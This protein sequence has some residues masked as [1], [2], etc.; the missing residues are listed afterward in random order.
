MRDLAIFEQPTG[1][2]MSAETIGVAG[3]GMRSGPA[4]LPQVLQN[5]L[6]TQ[7]CVC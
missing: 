3:I 2:G 5:P 4:A 6:L 7:T 1:V